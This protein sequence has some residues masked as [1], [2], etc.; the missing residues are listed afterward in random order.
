VRG[1][2]PWKDDGTDGLNV[3]APKGRI[4]TFAEVQLKDAGGKLS[5]PDG[6]ALVERGS[7]TWRWPV[8]VKTSDQR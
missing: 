6:V 7:K 2:T 5:T 1:G 4:S 8:E 3:G